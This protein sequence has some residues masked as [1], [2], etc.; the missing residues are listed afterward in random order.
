MNTLANKLSHI[1]NEI[2]FLSVPLE[3]GDEGMHGHDTKIAQIACFLS[4]RAICKYCLCF[5]SCTVREKKYIHSSE[6]RVISCSKVRIIR[7]KI[8]LRVNDFVYTSKKNDR[9]CK[10]FNWNN[11]N[12]ICIP[13]LLLRSPSQCLTVWACTNTRGYTHRNR[14]R[15]SYHICMESGACK[16]IV[17]FAWQW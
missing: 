14:I 17:W 5:S 6:R 7:E 10:Y 1:T 11:F 8:E 13:L 4:A 2:T 3:L 15:S 16:V 9:A 12:Y